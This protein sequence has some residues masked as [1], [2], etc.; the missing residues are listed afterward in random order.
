[1]MQRGKAV[2]DLTIVVKAPHSYLAR[3]RAGR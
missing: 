1:M 2:A 3:R